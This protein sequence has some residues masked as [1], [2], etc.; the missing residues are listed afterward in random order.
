MFTV[1]FIFNYWLHHRVSLILRSCSCTVTYQPGVKQ[2]LTLQSLTQPFHLASSLLHGV[3]Y[4][5]LFLLTFH[6]FSEYP[7]SYLLQNRL[8]SQLDKSLGAKFIFL[9]LGLQY[10]SNELKHTHLK[11]LAKIPGSLL[12]PLQAVMQIN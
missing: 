6:V 12:C 5:A 4:K 1:W 2:V 10:F 11:P 9:P 7:I 8:S 3:F